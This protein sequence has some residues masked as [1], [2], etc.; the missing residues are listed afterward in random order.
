MIGGGCL[1][2]NTQIP[3]VH[4][5]QVE[6][7]IKQAIKKNTITPTISH[8]CVKFVNFASISFLTG[9][10]LISVWGCTRSRLNFRYCNTKTETLSTAFYVIR[11]TDM[12]IF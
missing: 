2:I 3:K 11:K 9:N 12:L 4:P 8:L 10:P 7:Y 1:R 5:L 6:T